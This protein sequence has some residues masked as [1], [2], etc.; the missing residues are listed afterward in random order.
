MSY[1]PDRVHPV[2]L[3][4]TPSLLNSNLTATARHVSFA[5]KDKAYV[6]DADAVDGREG[7]KL[8][9]VPL[10][11]APLE[12]DAAGAR[13]DAAVTSI[14]ACCL[15]TSLLVVCSFSHVSVCTEDG[16]ALLYSAVSAAYTPSDTTGHF[17]SAVALPG[18]SK[19]AVGTSWGAIMLLKAEYPVGVAA[20]S[21]VMDGWLP[22][23]PV[24]A[25]VAPVACLATDGALLF[26]G[27]EDGRLEAWNCQGA[28]QA[29]EAVAVGVASA[30]RSLGCTIFDGGR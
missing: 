13:G 14:D 26:A 7:P 15:H 9:R 3:D 24:V 11:G 25:P 16:A 30:P 5:H 4:A 20:P 27:F 19:L 6:L 10:A 21:I 17:C 8:I 28:L 18:S 23:S 1:A 29:G 12:G 22:P 2:K